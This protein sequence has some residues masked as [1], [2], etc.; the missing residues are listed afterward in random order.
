MDESDAVSAELSLSDK[1][2]SLKEQIARSEGE[3]DSLGEQLRAVD[4][5]LA[6]LRERQPDFD[7]LTQACES[8]ADLESRGVANLFWSAESAAESREQHLHHARQNIAG[9]KAEVA[10]T[11]ERRDAIIETMNDGYG[12][13]DEL[14][15]ALRDVMA[16]EE[17]RRNEWVI[18]RKAKILPYY[19]Q[20]MPWARGCE[21]DQRFRRSLAASVLLAVMVGWLSTVI[22]LPIPERSQIIEVPER[23]ARLV[24]EEMRRPPPAQP[25]ETVA[26]PED[27]PEPEPELAKEQAPED[28]PESPEQG[29]VA[30]AEPAPVRE[31]IK[32]KGILAFR[33]SFASVASLRPSAQLGAEARIT[34]A[35][36]DA[37]GR[38]AR[39][40]VAT[41][42]PGSSGGINLAS[43]SRDVGG[44]GGGGGMAGVQVSRVASS[45]GGNG[46]GD[47]RPLS[48]GASAGRTDEEI[49]IVFDRYKASLYRLYNRELRKDPTLRGQLVL[50]MTIEPDGSVS[51]CALQSTDMN[52]PDLT[53]QI[54]QRVSAFDFGAKEDIVAVTIIYPIDFL[55]A[56]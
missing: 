33:E 12:G 26:V 17:S 11:E 23:V 30:D 39:S 38:T 1:E 35:G 25:E 7:A 21:E 13:L 4:A 8:L 22:D 3:I 54:V 49:Q 44:G 5:E 10:L 20:V 34:S 28:L 51:F 55:P 15:Y 36:A 42:A 27:L 56:A 16:A 31:Q 47:G 18:E 9:F 46:S 53:Q 41:L 32:A 2:R 14:H 29:M 37:V 6:A 52:A 19:A 50:R 45:I 48:G 43:I 24:R 40:M